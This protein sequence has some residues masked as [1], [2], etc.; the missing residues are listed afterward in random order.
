MRHK[1]A[2][3]IIQWANGAQRISPNGV[4]RITV[5]ARA[6]ERAHGIGV[7]DE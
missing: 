1:H 6:I 4:T 2:D 3:L 7:E 5:F